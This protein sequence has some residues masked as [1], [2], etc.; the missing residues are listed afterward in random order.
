MLGSAGRDARRDFQRVT[1]HSEDES[2]ITPE[3]HMRHILLATTGESP[4]VVTETL[5]GMHKDGKPWPDAIRIITTT[6]GD[7]RAREGLL[8]QG[9]LKRLCDEIGRPMPR[10]S[11]ADIRIVP[12]AQGEPVDDARSLAACRT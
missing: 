3:H 2:L 7:K 10:F 6:L 1:Q 4:Q 9:Q 5:Y 8:E 12:N 11:A